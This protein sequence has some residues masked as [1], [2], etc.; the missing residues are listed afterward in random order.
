MTGRSDTYFDRQQDAG[1]HQRNHHG[2]SSPC[3]A[4]APVESTGRYL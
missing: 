4:L 1:S 2:Y 3:R